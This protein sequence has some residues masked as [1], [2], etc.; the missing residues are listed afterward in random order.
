M[1]NTKAK[2]L[3]PIVEIVQIGI[4]NLI[5]I[6]HKDLRKYIGPLFRHPINKWNINRVFSKYKKTKNIGLNNAR[7]IVIVLI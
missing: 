5:S 4:Q 2:Y 3:G 1:I 7:I 6:S